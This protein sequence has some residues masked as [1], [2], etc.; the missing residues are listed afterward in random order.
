[1]A[2]IYFIRHGETDWNVEGRTQGHLAVPLN[3]NGRSQAARN[4]R[5]L[6]ELLGDALG[7]DFVASPLLR[8]RQTMEIIRGEMGLPLLEY[9]TDDRLKEIGRGDWAGYLRSELRTRFPVDARAYEA[10]WWNFVTPGVGGESFAMLSERV[11]GWFES[12]EQDT[13]VVSHGGPMRCIRR[14][15]LGL[16]SEGALQLD[17][18]QDKVMRIEN[19]ALSW[20]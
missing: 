6:R 14:R 3:D 8:T 4:G 15:L 13:V 7:F 17:A 12:V 16:D 2:V 11:C 18:P 5:M 20:F 1:M 10:D 19:G 9:R